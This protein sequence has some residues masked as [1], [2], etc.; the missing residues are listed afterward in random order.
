[1][2]EL[3][4]LVSN[5]ILEAAREDYKKRRASKYYLYSYDLLE[6]NIEDGISDNIKN[7]KLIFSDY[8]THPRTLRTRVNKKEISIGR[9]YIVKDKNILIFHHH[10]QIL[11]SYHAVV[12][13]F[14]MN[15][16]ISFKKVGMYLI[17]NPENIKVN[18]YI[19]FDKEKILVRTEHTKI[20]DVFVPSNRA[21][22]LFIYDYS[23]LYTE[24]TWHPKY[25]NGSLRQNINFNDFNE[26]KIHIIPM[27][28]NSEYTI[29]NVADLEEAYSKKMINVL[30][31]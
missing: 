6:S 30:T 26:Y 9:F 16:N 13:K 17:F 25:I 15:K 12:K 29:K 7:K 4:D 1:M 24:N 18:E 10:G 14:K 19:I 11:N 22:R 8:R 20:K 27:L 21:T 23:K 3:I 28:Y 5:I 31:T 2:N